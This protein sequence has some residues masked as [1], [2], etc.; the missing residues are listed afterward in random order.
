MLGEAAMT[1]TDA[2]RY[3][4]DYLHAIEEV[5]KMQQIEIFTT[6]TVFL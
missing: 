6:V 2:D 5:G 4:N 3:F 1:A